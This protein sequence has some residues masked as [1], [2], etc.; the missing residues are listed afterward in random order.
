[1]AA[2]HSR[3]PASIDLNLLRVFLAVWESHSLTLAGEHLGLSQPAVSHALR[4]LR[5]LFGDPLF[6]RVGTS[7]TPTDAA[8]QLH[9]PIDEALGIIGKALQTRERFEPASASRTFR[10]AMSDMSEFFF[11]P[12]LLD[13]LQREAPQVRFDV[14]Q[15]AVD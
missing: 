11:L 4:R 15:M 13:S 7:M 3:N 2:M 14:V 12:P 6:V 1:M 10:L 9:A 5:D 8:M